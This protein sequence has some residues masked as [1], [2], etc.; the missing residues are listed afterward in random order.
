M[1]EK[2]GKKRTLKRGKEET[3]REPGARFSQCCG[4]EIGKNGNRRKTKETKVHEG[5]AP[6]TKRRGNITK[7]LHT[8]EGKARV[9]YSF[10]GKEGKAKGK[11]G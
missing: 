10:G 9:N 5:H 4:R 7:S 11:T 8:T 1:K 6:Q 2:V 3:T